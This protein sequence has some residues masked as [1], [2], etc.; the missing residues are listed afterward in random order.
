MLDLLQT[1]KLLI[2]NKLQM[3]SSLRPEL[4]NKNTSVDTPI[5]EADKCYTKADE[6]GKK[7]YKELLNKTI[8]DSTLKTLSLDFMNWKKQHKSKHS[9]LS[10]CKNIQ[11]P[12]YEDSQSY[13]NWL[14]NTNHLPG[15]LDRS[16]SFL[17]MRDMGKSIND[18]KVKNEIN[19]VTKKLLSHL[20]N[21]EP[22][23][24]KSID[25]QL[26]KVYQLAKEEGLAHSLTWYFEKIKRFSENIPDGCDKEHMIRKIVNFSA[27]V[28]LNQFQNMDNNLPKAERTKKLQDAIRIGYYYS[29]TYPFIDDLLEADSILNEKERFQFSDALEKTLKTGNVPEM[30]VP[31]GQNKKFTSFVYSELKEAFK[32]IKASIPEENRKS[33]FEKAYIF[34]K[35]QEVDRLK[36]LDNKN[37]T[38][39]DLYV[40]VMLKSSSAWHI[41]YS[42]LGKDEKKDK[43]IDER[44]F[45]FGILSQLED[46]LYDYKEDLKEGKVTPF[47]YYLTHHKDRPD[48]VNPSE[49][50]WSV[51]SKLIH[52][53][54]KDDP[55]A[56]EALLSRAVADHKHIMSKGLA[57]YNK[58]FQVFGTHNKTFNDIVKKF[59]RKSE[60]SYFM[61]KVFRHAAIEYYKKSKN[62]Q[63]NFFSDLKKIGKKIDQML[64][65]E[66]DD[67]DKITG[68][69][70]ADGANYSLSAGGKRIRPLLAY[71]MGVNGYHLNEEN[72][73]PL[74][75]SIEYM[76]TAS[77]IFD[78]L[79]TEDNADL[80]RG[81][82]TLHKYLNSPAAA[83]LTGLYLVMKA[84]EEEAKLIGFDA[85]RVQSLIK[86]GSRVIQ[87]MCKGQYMDIES[88][89][90]TLTISQL[91][92]LCFYKTGIAME[93]SLIM[94]AILANAP[95]NEM[96]SIRK[97]AR[98]AGI[99]FQ[100][101]DDI[102][103][104][105]GDSE[106]MGKA[107]GI[108]TTNNNSTFVTVLGIDEA[109][110]QL[111]D[112]YFQALSALSEIP[113]DTKFLKQVLNYIVTRDH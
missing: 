64:P 107:T 95:K 111:F 27:E 103:D 76:H 89:N 28:M 71:A 100:I 84:T 61:D 36:T 50:Y 56:Q 29:I 69:T 59:T 32:E 4:F 93:A 11:E 63:K 8:S 39:E 3:G 54:Y 70:L 101:K 34:Y 96:D 65:I 110:V 86:Y 51:I 97:F 9:I 37:Y 98:H 83:E 90:K 91:E 35:A 45:C 12:G 92:S 72:L 88:K 2:D 108:D 10:C 52:D 60:D 31:E 57:E 41:M 13:M 109:K 16:I 55:S 77:L 79:P 75:R 22:I 1:N 62:D 94:P 102:L 68:G 49:I 21:S 78:D 80:R 38:N 81:K 73:K 53:V 24:L 58:C 105:E 40:P 18:P 14:K 66:H 104:L 33:F 23:Q 113:R 67:A 85:K 46:D 106:K 19:L 43:G 17:Y 6:R 87:D 99:A 20:E 48:L 15:F 25:K 30:K 74:L 82:P 26:S 44:T 5:I 7:Y 47:T 42:M 112:H